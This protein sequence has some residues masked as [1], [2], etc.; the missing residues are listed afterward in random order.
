MTTCRMVL[1]LLTIF[2]QCW[3]LG[4]ASTLLVELTRGWSL[5]PKPLTSMLFEFDAWTLLPSW[6]SADAS[7][8]TVHRRYCLSSSHTIRYDASHEIAWSNDCLLSNIESPLTSCSIA[9][10]LHWHQINSEI[11]CTYCLL[12]SSSPCLSNALWDA[13]SIISLCMLLHRP[14]APFWILET[15]LKSVEIPLIEQRA[16]KKELL[17]FVGR[18]QGKART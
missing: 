11:F 18:G 9:D 6:T 12:A 15:L 13:T 2:L 1:C 7:A 14:T 16:W 4:S 10:Q 17:H 5:Y 8:F 3:P